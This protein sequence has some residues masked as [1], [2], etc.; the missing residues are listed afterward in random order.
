MRIIA[1]LRE[2]QSPRNDE[3][4]MLINAHRALKNEKTKET[5]NKG[6]VILRSCTKKL[7]PLAYLKCVDE[8]KRMHR[9]DNTVNTVSLV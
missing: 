2:L 3:H 7:D 5:Y 1:L 6:N 9:R 8:S 4:R